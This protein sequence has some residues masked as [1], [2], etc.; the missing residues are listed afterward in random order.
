MK[1]N[2][3]Q[4]FYIGL[5]FFVISMFG[6]LYD[7]IIGKMAINSYGLGHFWSGVLLALDNILALF[8]IPLFGSL[9]DKTKTKHGRRTPYIFWGI[10][11]SAVLIPAI[12]MFDANQQKKV[13]EA[14]IPIVETIEETEDGKYLFNGEVYEKEKDALKAQQALVFEVTK[15][16]MTNFI[17]FLLV[18]FLVLTVMAAYRSPAVALMPDVTLKPLRSKANAII[19]LMGS[20]GGALFLVMS[21]FLA[22]DY[23]SYVTLFLIVSGIMIACLLIFLWKVKEP[24]L[25]EKV[26]KEKQ[27]YGFAE[28]E[29]GETPGEEAPMPADVKRSFFLILASIVFW[30]MAYNAAISKFSVYA[31]QV[32]DLHFAMAL[33][34]AHGVAMIAFLPIGILSSKIGRKKMIII[35]IIILA[36]AFTLGIIANKSTKF[37]IYVTL[38]LA[39]IG[40]ATINV[41]SYPMIVEMS[42]GSNVGK[43]TGFYYTASM[44]AQIVTPIISGYL[45]ENVN[46]RTLFP[47]SLFFT[48][49][50]LVTMM[51]VKHGDAKKI[52]QA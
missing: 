47:Y 12:A 25:V 36:V 10:I 42:K 8:L 19:N 39:G 16:N 9:S 28:E 27:L 45:M 43:Y 3:K 2:I 17:C 30:F 7:A 46:L 20:I 37:L 44:S 48:L 49:L 18:I 15:G 1:L 32:L 5:A 38:S 52:E 31:Q 4:V 51:F 21:H 22:R 50:A 41:N 14:E 35:G 34:I 6:S 33:L 13:Q 40:W 24:L 23:K 29:E 11:L 26:N